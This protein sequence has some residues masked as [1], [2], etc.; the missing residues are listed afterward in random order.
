M[1]EFGPYLPDLAAFRNPGATVA[2]NVLPRSG[3]GYEPFPALAAVS[4]AMNAYCRGAAALTDSTGVVY[5]YA[6]TGTR[7]YELDGVA[8]VNVTRAS[9]GDYINGTDDR[10]EFVKWG[11]TCIAVNFADAVQS[12]TLGGAN[13]AALITSVLRPRAKHIA[14]QGDFVVLGNTNDATDGD[15]QNRVW[16]SAINNP[17]DFQPAAATQCDNQDLQGAG[18]EIQRLASMGDFLGIWTRR[19]LW[20]MTYVGGAPIFT[21][22]EVEQGRGTPAPGSVV[23][24]GRIA[25]WLAD[26][27]FYAWDGVTVTPIG[28][29]K[30][31]RTFLAEVDETFYGM[32]SAAI[33]PT[34]KVVVWAYPTSASSGSGIPDK[35]IAYNWQEG[36]WSDVVANMQ[37]VY[38][39]LSA[40]LTLENL[41]SIN[42][43][44]DDLPLSLDS[45]AWAG[46]AATLG[47][48]TTLHEMGTFSGSNLAATVETGEMQL[49]PGE[50]ALVTEVMPLVDG[51][52]LTMALGVR[53]IVTAA[54]SFTASVAVDA[55][56][57]CAFLSNARYH[58]ARVSVA[59]AGTWNHAQGIDNIIAEPQGP[60]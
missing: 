14:V 28:G 36:R 49:F 31:D 25:F 40:G 34:R 52:T 47:G 39:A 23:T 11:N 2:R 3:G 35:L 19:G 13:F 46:G 27:G 57:R 1:I 32:I 7:L 38:P 59:A 56:G 18:G 50:R 8:V 30:V 15:V 24:L 21:I 58:R 20:R 5:T 33:D 55:A 48:F 4:T 17:A 6:G 12:I 60:F 41:D 16:W 54:A 53:D 44:L 26:D 37:I 22:I 45:S 29:G 10:W 9:G 51:G 43:S 42:A